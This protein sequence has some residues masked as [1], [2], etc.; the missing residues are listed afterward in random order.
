M[1]MGTY[2]VRGSGH[3]RFICVSSH[4]I[5]LTL[6]SQSFPGHKIRCLPFWPGAGSPSS[7]G[8]RCHLLV[9][10]RWSPVLPMPV[11]EA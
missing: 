4:T 8:E 7:M 9:T 3:L 6:K 2:Y 11:R 5:S 1:A 10:H